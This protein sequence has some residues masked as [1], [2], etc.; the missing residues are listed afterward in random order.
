M[1][2][3][4]KYIVGPVFV[5]LMLIALY[6]LKTQKLDLYGTGDSEGSSKKLLFGVI[7]K[8]QSAGITFINYPPVVREN[9]KHV[10]SFFR[11]GA[12]V[13]VADFN[14]DGFQDFFVTSN[15]L[16][17]P[18]ALY[19]NTGNGSFL[20]VTS[21]VGLLDSG[22]KNP[23]ARAL[24]LD[25]NDDGWE[26]LFVLSDCSRVFANREGSFEEITE[27]AFGASCIRGSVAA[28]VIDYNNDK[29]LDLI[30]GHYFKS[31]IFAD[32]GP[33]KIMPSNYRDSNNQADLF[34][35][36]NKG[37][38]RFAKVEHDIGIRSRGWNL[39]IGV[40][41]LR[42][43]ILKDIWLSQDYG[44]DTL[45]VNNGDG[46][47]DVDRETMNVSSSSRNSMN[48]DVAY[49]EN[50]DQPFLQTSHIFNPQEK[51]G[52]N[53][54]WKFLP[55]G[56]L[57]ESAMKWKLN[58]CGWSWGSKFIDVDNNGLLDLVTT[59]GFIT[60]SSYDEYWFR[61]AS[62][63][64][65]I[66]SLMEDAKNWPPIG[67]MSFGGHQRDCIFYNYGEGNFHNVVERTAFDI[68][69]NDGRALAI[70]DV[71][72]NGNQ[73][74]LVANQKGPL[75]LYQF[76]PLKRNNWIGFSLKGD[77]E[78][79]RGIGAQL[80]LQSENTVFRRELQPL[81][82]FSSQSEARLHV[83]LGAISNIVSAEV[84]WPDGC[85]QQ[86]LPAEVVLNQYNQVEKTCL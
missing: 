60:N 5:A 1:Q 74:L 82:G 6:A 20:D 84:I 27:Q 7:D 59:N 81:N 33:T 65:G 76:Q 19:Q 8:T 41:S 53:L 22:K 80:R 73:A 31:S 49:L 42:N 21:A 44:T 70:I 40:H 45:F 54:L 38:C 47:F 36:K 67:E 23:T 57:K 34:V 56:S 16:D 51:T 85:K 14:K 61:I 18:N 26:E 37:Q 55:D 29:R 43:K 24:F 30:L 66:G 10:E 86:L 48:V 72:N 64:G 12:S 25:C 52:G 4:I 75:K 50:T 35:M 15:R 13:A 11:L 63:A 17:K 46:T 32:A 9:L 28:N 68:E 2:N 62:L 3:R 39:A 77:K 71:Q 79:R 83:G 58:A 78:N 69:K